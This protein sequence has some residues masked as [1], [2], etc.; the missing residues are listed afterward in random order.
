VITLDARGEIVD[1][2]ALLDPSLFPHFGLPSTPP[3]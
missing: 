1:A 2:V 3:G